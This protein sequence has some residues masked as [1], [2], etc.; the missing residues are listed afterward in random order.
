MY[1]IFMYFC[2]VGLKKNV[3]SSPTPAR[4]NKVLWTLQFNLSN[5]ALQRI[6]NIIISSRI[7]ANLATTA[8]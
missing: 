4:T 6:I 8:V 1:N 2:T 5:V 3:N 7:F